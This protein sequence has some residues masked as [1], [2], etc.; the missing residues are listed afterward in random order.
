MPPIPLEG[1]VIKEAG[2]VSDNLEPLIAIRFVDGPQ[3]ECV[4]DTGFN[5]SLFLPR[6]FIEKSGFA[7]IGEE[8]FHSVG[9]GEPHIAEV[10]AASLNWLGEEIE[11]SVI[12]SEHGSSLLGA[13][14]MIGCKLEVDYSASTVIIEKA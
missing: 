6:D 9:Q 1:T 8:T 5:G 10:F 3:I 13:G 12:A 2:E 14:L 4:V 11:V 7:L